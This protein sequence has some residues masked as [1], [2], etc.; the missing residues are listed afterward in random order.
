LTKQD[1][2]QE[3]V[4]PTTGAWKKKAGKKREISGILTFDEELCGGA[5]GHQSAEVTIKAC[6][7]QSSVRTVFY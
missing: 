5:M 6:L 1:K 3:Q 2:K 7:V 4:H